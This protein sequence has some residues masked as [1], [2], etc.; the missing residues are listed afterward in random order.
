MLETLTALLTMYRIPTVFAGAFFFGDSVILTA[1]YLAGQ[2]NWPII[3]IF[4]AAFLGT[5]TADTMWFFAGVFFARRFSGIEFMR[6]RREKAAALLRKITGEKPAYALI[7]IKFLYGS[8]IAMI[9]YVAARGLSF[10][11]FSIYNSIGIFVWLAIF[12]PIGYFAGRGI[13]TNFPIMNAIEAAVVVLVV[14]F[15]LMRILTI[16]LTKQVTNE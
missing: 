10:R 1:A 8:R 2:L 6:E 5:A 16:W 4:L 9:L 12:F 15:I 14:S 7:I 11:T 3:P 13:S